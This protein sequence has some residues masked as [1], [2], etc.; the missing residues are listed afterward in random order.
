MTS[1]P[2]VGTLLAVT[3]GGT[4]DFET[5]ACGDMVGN[6]KRR[7]TSTPGVLKCSAFRPPW[8]WS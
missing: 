8:G 7:P 5:I 3:L 1:R 6:R 4:D 2:N